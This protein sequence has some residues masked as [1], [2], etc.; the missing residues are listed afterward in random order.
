MPHISCWTLLWSRQLLLAHP[1]LPPQHTITLPPLGWVFPG[2]FCWAVASCPAKVVAYSQHS[3]WRHPCTATDCSGRLESCKCGTASHAGQLLPSPRPRIFIGCC[4]MVGSTAFPVWRPREENGGDGQAFQT[5]RS[6][7][8]SSPANASERMR[9]PQ[10]CT[11]F[12]VQW[13]E[14]DHPLP[15]NTACGAELIFPHFI[16]PPEITN[17]SVSIPNDLSFPWWKFSFQSK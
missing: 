16:C 12:S 13:A 17:W 8:P 14:H 9:E 2:A 15:T 7:S 6:E 4:T 5:S 3:C 1:F 11:F 10:F